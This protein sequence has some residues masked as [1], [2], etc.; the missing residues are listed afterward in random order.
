MTGALTTA[1]IILGRRIYVED[2]QGSV[3]AIDRAT[4]QVVWRSKPT[5]LSIGPDGVAVGWGKVFAATSDG[6]IALN[7]GNGATVWSRRLTATAGVDIQPTVV[8]G[9]VLVATVPVSVANGIYRAG[10]SGWLFALDARTGHTD[11]AFDTVASPDLWGIRRSTRAAVRGTRRRSTSLPPRLL[12]NGEPRPV[13]GHSAVPKR[14]EPT[15]A[16]PVHRFHGGAQPSD[17][18]IDLV[19]PGDL[20]RHLR[21]RLRPHHDRRH[22]GIL[23]APGHRGNR[24][25][26]QGARARPEVRPAPVAHGCR[27]HHNGELKASQA[28]PK[29][30]P[31]PTEACS[32]RPHR[33]TA[34]RTWPH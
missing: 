25:E 4:G 27:M 32:H 10:D 24:Q 5:G 23:A 3:A 6:V 9:R 14:D 8:E 30:F 1:P 7:A 17:R 34:S 2:D 16:E 15:W 18:K 19:S 20:T 12:G 11:W 13:P 22:P 33:Q 28:P 26:R 21:S 29:F 31:A